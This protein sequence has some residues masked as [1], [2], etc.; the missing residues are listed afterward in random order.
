M[1]PCKVCGSP[2]RDV[3]GK[4]ILFKYDVR[5]VLCGSCGFLATE[6][7]WWLGEAYSEALMGL[8][9][10]GMV[11]RNLQVADIAA[12]LIID[13]LTLPDPLWT[14]AAGQVCW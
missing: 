8:R 5:Y 3:F 11:Q 9:D 12:D 7:P 1:T 6:T 4:R 14:T 2:T 13:H 10:V